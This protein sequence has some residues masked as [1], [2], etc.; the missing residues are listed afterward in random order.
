[1]HGTPDR[2]YGS[3]KGLRWMSKDTITFGYF[4]VTLDNEYKF[5]SLKQGKDSMTSHW[6]LTE[7]AAKELTN[8]HK[9]SFNPREM[10]IIQ[11]AIRMKG[12][13]TGRCWID[14]KIISF[15]LPE[16]DE[17]RDFSYTYIKPNDLIKVLTD[18]KINKNDYDNWT[19]VTVHA[20]YN[21]S[22]YIA[23]QSSIQNQNF[24][25]YDPIY[26][27]YSDWNMSDRLIQKIEYIVNPPSD[28]K[29]VQIDRKLK[30]MPYAKYRSM[31]NQEGKNGRQTLLEYYG[32]PDEI[33]DDSGKVC[34]D[35]N[36]R[37][38][39]SFGYF[40]VS[41]DEYKFFSKNGVTHMR[42]AELACSDFVRSIRNK[43]SPDEMF[44]LVEAIYFKG[45]F[46]GRYWE[47]LHVISFWSNFGK[48]SPNDLSRIMNQLNLN[49][50]EYTLVMGKDSY[51]CSSYIRGEYNIKHYYN[52]EFYMED[53]FDVSNELLKKIKLNVPDKL[54]KKIENEKEAVSSKRQQIDKNL[55]NMTYA[56][57]RSLI[58]QENKKPKVINITENQYSKLFEK[59]KTIKL[60]EEQMDKLIKNEQPN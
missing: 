56:Q 23:D 29:R 53:E 12:I 19:L 13:F 32:N 10:S 41:M 48:I 49:P 44:E 51:P 6:E 37:T 2:I 54:L 24:T 40:P 30:G 47:H 52:P 5:F 11:S 21:V 45:I 55:G 36:D 22:E 1:M 25:Y 60:T 20:H 50:N 7:L 39:V 16:N 43:I 38:C 27:I 34:A 26:K 4:P 14:S 31:L 46:L 8:N 59:K 42:L 58:Y 17:E 33:K 57:Y 9:Y 3:T 15:W 18:L 35:F 28:R